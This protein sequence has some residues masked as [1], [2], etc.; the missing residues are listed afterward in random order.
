[1]EILHQVAPTLKSA[2][3][4]NF[5]VNLC[6][7]GS[8]GEYLNDEGQIIIDE[9]EFLLIMKLKDLKKQYRADFNELQ[10]VRREVQYCQHLVD[11]CRNRLVTGMAGGRLLL[12]ADPF[13]RA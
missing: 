6:V 9:E 8:A 1:M 3:L 12:L 2:L 5:P 10:N 13:S 7:W 11:Q 4:G